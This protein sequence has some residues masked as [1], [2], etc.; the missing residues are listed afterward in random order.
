[1]IGED[2]DIPNSAAVASSIRTIEE[3]LYHNLLDMRQRCES[4]LFRNLPPRDLAQASWSVLDVQVCVFSFCRLWIMKLFLKVLNSITPQTDLESV[5]F[6]LESPNG[7]EM[8]SASLS[9][10]IGILLVWSVT[11]L[12][13][14]EHRPYAV[15][16]LLRQWKEK[17]NE[18]SLRRESASDP[19]GSEDFPHDCLFDWLDNSHVAGDPNNLSS[20]ALL[21]CE[22]IKRGLFSYSKYTQR[23]IARGDVGLSVTDVSPL[24]Y[25]CSPTHGTIG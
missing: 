25:A 3:S 10:R 9:E 24:I 11:P 8:T 23:L 7:K 18:R 19:T 6:L 17:Q 14:G 20:V 13:Y 15:A 22:L 21:Y 1:M 12:Q 4:M 16:A 5:N 2:K